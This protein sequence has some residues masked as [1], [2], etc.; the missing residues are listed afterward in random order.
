[1]RIT[2]LTWA[3]ATLAVAFCGAAHGEDG[4]TAGIGHDTS[5][6]A[7]LS[8]YEAGGADRIEGWL[9]DYLADALRWGNR[10]EARNTTTSRVLLGLEV[11]CREQPD[12]ALADAA[13]GVV[14][15]VWEA[16]S[17]GR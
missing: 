11:R 15:D 7:F 2:G 8:R 14:W 4:A 10:P 12:V 5:C 17:Q 3:T 1:M 9:E 16:A 13:T 6:G